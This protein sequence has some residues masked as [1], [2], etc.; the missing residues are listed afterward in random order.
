MD[1]YQSSL[2]IALVC[3][4]VSG[5]G[6]KSDLPL[7]HGR[8]GWGISGQPEAALMGVVASMQQTMGKAYETC[9]Q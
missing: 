1:S 4:Q 7:G 3:L 2:P 6:A 5:I 9:F 8:R